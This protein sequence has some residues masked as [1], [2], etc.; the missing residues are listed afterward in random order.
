MIKTSEKCSNKESD[1]IAELSEDSLTESFL[2]QVL[3]ILC[4]LVL[5]GPDLESGH[6][7]EMR[8]KLCIHGF[9]WREFPHFFHHVLPSFLSYAQ[10]IF[11]L[12]N[13][14]N[15]QAYLFMNIRWGI[16]GKR[17]RWRSVSF[18]F[19]DTVAAAPDL[20]SA[21]LGLVLILPC[22]VCVT[23]VKCSSPLLACFTILSN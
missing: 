12:P 14:H 8:T 20:K 3:R 9:F 5:H 16:W 19:G 17:E 13:V 18:L 2:L 15:S 1:W 11:S 4:P 10:V 7:L 22:T 6:L 23:L 21:G